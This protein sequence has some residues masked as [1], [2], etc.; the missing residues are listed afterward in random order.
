MAKKNAKHDK[1]VKDAYCLLINYRKRLE[2]RDEIAEAERVDNAAKLL[3]LMCLN[4]E[5]P[6]SGEP[7]CDNPGL[8]ER[9][10]KDEQAAN[11][12]YK[13]YEQYIE[14]IS[15]QYA[16]VA[17]DDGWGGFGAREIARKLHPFSKWKE[18]QRILSQM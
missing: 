16:E 1:A 14:E 17:G 10:K 8:T 9:T 4:E 15:G 5:A 13:R 7:A 12:E 2:S 18:R 3:W 6:W 11:D